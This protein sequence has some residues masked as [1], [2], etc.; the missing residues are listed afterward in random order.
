MFGK[1]LNGIDKILTFLENWTLFISVMAALLALFFNVVL[2]YTINYTLAWSEELVREVIIFTTFIGCGA[3]VKYRSM[4]KIDALV[5]LVPKLKLPLTYFSHLATIV[6]SLMMLYYGW[7]IAA[8][9]VM[10]NQ[11]TIIMEIPLVYLYSFL[12][13]MGATML[14]RTIQVIYQDLQEQRT[15]K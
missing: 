8:L 12:P 9:Q 4:I 2:R 13:I 15:S 3:A 14:I 11:K 5:Q 10:T 6:F 7:K 1:V